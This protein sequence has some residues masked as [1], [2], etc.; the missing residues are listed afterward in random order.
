MRAICKFKRRGDNTKTFGARESR[1]TTRKGY[2][3]LNLTGPPAI[4]TNMLLLLL[5]LILP[6]LLG[7]DRR[8][9]RAKRLQGEV[10]KVTPTLFVCIYIY[11][12]IQ[13]VLTYI[14]IYIYYIYIY[15]YIYTYVY[16]YIYI[17]EREMY[18]YVY[19]HTDVDT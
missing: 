9:P 18:A 7:P 11:I 14:H 4:P 17:Y 16:I 3:K 19:V 5:L 12:Y 6:I 8:V 15:I 1:Q 10:F 2:S 13:H